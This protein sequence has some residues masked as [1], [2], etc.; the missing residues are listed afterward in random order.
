VILLECWDNEPNNRPTM[1]QVV[2]KLKEIIKNSNQSS[3]ELQINYS[4]PN[5]IP[6]SFYDLIWN[7]LSIFQNM[8]YYTNEPKE[9][10]E[11]SDESDESD[12]SQ[13]DTS[14]DYSPTNGDFPTN[15]DSPERNNSKNNNSSLHGDLS[16]I[17]NNFDIMNSEEFIESFTN[18]T[19]NNVSLLDD[20]PQSNKDPADT[21]ELAEPS[22]QHREFNIGNVD[23]NEDLPQ[24]NENAD[25]LGSKKGK[26][27]KTRKKKSIMSIINFFRKNLS[28][29]VDEIIN[30]I[31]QMTNEGK[32]W[33]EQKNILLDY[34][35]TNNINSKKFY[36][37]LL[38]NQ[39]ISKNTFLLGY[40]NH[41][42]IETDE[43]SEKAFS[44]FINA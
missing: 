33:D 21:K 17:M 1:K 3:S 16:L 35:I 22:E 13:V 11:T 20:S 39:H 36:N 4:K 42:G 18:D 12:E 32:V 41:L 2:A 38:S 15:G 34:F 27:T 25:N 9:N 30:V 29:S 31:I 10:L 28:I 26:S 43:D 8:Y 19:A 40:F 5:I 14:N 37:W 44:L 24:T 7:T 23:N 6:I